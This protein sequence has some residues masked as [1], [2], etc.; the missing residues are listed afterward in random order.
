MAAKKSKDRKD[1]GR[2]AR[3]IADAVRVHPGFQLADLDPSAT[4]A[5]TGKKADGEAA[6]DAAV[7]PLAQLQE[8]L[9]AQSRTGDSKRSVLLVLQGMD[10]SGKGGI[11]R[12]VVGNVDPQGVRHTA[13]KAPTEEERAHDFLWRI[14]RAL[15]EA[16]EL[17]VFDRSHYED[18]LAVRVHELLPRNAW[19]RRYAVINKF[20]EGLVSE[21]TTVL[22]VMLHISPDEQKAR[23]MERLERPDKHWKYNPGDVDDRKHWD[24]YQ[25]AYQ[26]VLTRCSTDVAPWHVVPADR[27]WY[28]RYAVQQ[29]LLDALCAIDPQWPPADYDI[30]VEKG[31]LAAT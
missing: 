9:W 8:R 30:E 29:L 21:G 15:P 17:G 6:L 5:F 4:P 14:R 1:A 13:F 19:Q 25:V 3:R 11:L 7:K 22:K 20:E 12:H 23:L 24:A 16:G 26:D 28:A 10:T 31:R 27:K 18:V 2:T